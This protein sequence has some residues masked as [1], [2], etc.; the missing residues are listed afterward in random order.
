MQLTMDL[1]ALNALGNTEASRMRG[2]FHTDQL[3][4]VGVWQA[5]GLLATDAADVADLADA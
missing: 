5:A 4:R 3:A 2:A 1:W